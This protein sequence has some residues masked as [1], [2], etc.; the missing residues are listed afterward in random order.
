MIHADGVLTFGTVGGSFINDGTIYAGALDFQSAAGQVFETSNSL[1][2]DGAATSANTIDLAL[3]GGTA[4]FDG[5][6]DNTFTFDFSPNTADTLALGD[7]PDFHGTIAGFGSGDAIDFASLSDVAITG[8]D[9]QR[10]QRRASI[11]RQR[12]LA[13]FSLS[14]VGNYTANSF[15]LA[16]DGTG[17]TELAL[18]AHRSSRTMRC[19]GTHA[20]R[21]QLHHV[22][23]CR[24]M[25]SIPA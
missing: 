6:V 8:Y 18:P 24:S 9:G 22:G 20:E 25:T 14:F 19:R 17:G 7:G 10:R 2:V 5:S 23:S 4:T 13:T 21:R 11:L 15:V 12:V 16:G 1:T 3:Q